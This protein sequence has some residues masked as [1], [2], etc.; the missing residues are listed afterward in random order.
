[1]PFPKGQGKGNGNLIPLLAQT[2]F[3]FGQRPHFGTK[4][5]RMGR[6]SPRPSIRPPHPRLRPSQLGLRPSQPG[7]RLRQP[8]RPEAS[9]LW[10]GWMAQRGERTD[11]RTD[12]GKIS[13]FHRTLSPIGAAAL[14]PKGSSRPTKRSRAR[15]PLTILCLWATVF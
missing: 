3:F 6:F 12:V 5:C 11:G 7:L 10:P 8:A 1:M 9:A 14:L 2:L 4:S 13:P 15:E